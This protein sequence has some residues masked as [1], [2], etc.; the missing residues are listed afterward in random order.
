M[1]I[2]EITPTG[3]ATMVPTGRVSNNGII[4]PSNGEVATP[5]EVSIPWEIIAPV[6]NPVPVQVA[7]L[8]PLSICDEE[9]CR[10]ID[11]TCCYVNPVFGLIH[12]SDGINPEYPEPDATYENDFNTWFV[13][14]SQ[15]TAMGADVQYW[16][17][18]KVD[19]NGDWQEIVNPITS[20]Y[21]T[22]HGINTITGHKTYV[23]L[24]LNWGKV[25]FEEGPGCYRAKL[26]ST[27][28]IINPAFPVAITVVVACMVTDCFKVMAWDCDRAKGTVK[29]ET[30]MSGK[31][32][33]YA[34]DYK[35]F[36]FC[37]I[38]VYDSIRVRG[39]FGYETVPEYLKVRNE[40]QTGLI[41]EVRNEAIQQ[42]KYNSFLLPKYIHDRFKVYGCMADTLQVSDYNVNNSD[43]DIRRKNVKI[44]GAYEPTYYDKGFLRMSKVSVNFRRGIQ[45]VIKT[46]CCCD[47][48]IKIV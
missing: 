14:M 28:T 6:I 17:L 35:L 3:G 48:P 34:V 41:D 24:E 16:I 26:K 37:G 19:S 43:Y 25:L 31:I 15:L 36:D 18:E 13:D 8:S 46:K 10:S 1:P 33:S 32:G 30:N 20:D 5:S 21:G 11:Q 27:I 39:F 45:G 9:E 40:Y 29:W 23:G 22:I 44:E 12:P 4:L 42:F 7:G 2:V 47:T 38:N